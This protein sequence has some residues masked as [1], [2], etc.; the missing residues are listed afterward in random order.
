MFYKKI[1]A[2]FVCLFV[3]SFV[4]W[5]VRSLTPRSRRPGGASNIRGRWQELAKDVPRG[6]VS[7]KGFIQLTARTRDTAGWLRCAHPTARAGN[8]SIGDH[9]APCEGGAHR[10]LSS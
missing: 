5:F 7:G 8:C 6:N 9:W 1:S 3:S 4:I 2:I 10:T